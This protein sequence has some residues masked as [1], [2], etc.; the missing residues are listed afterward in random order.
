MFYFRKNRYIIDFLGRGRLLTPYLNFLGDILYA[1]LVNNEENIE[2][3]PDKDLW[4]KD[5]RNIN[6]PIHQLA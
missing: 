3:R 1:I 4:V 6:G 5:R 2:N